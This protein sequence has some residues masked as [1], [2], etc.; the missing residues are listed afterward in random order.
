MT[1]K[2][3][4]NRRKS[5]IAGAKSSL[6]LTGAAAKRE[7]KARSAISA[8]AEQAAASKQRFLRDVDD[9]KLKLALYE[10]LR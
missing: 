9:E 8:A 2:I 10:A 3:A 5:R 1:K 4:K 6:S 7:A